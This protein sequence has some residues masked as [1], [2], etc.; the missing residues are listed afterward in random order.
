MH[1]RSVRHNIRLVGMACA[2]GLAALGIGQVAVDRLMAQGA[3]ADRPAQFEVDPFWPKQLPN[4]WIMGSVVGVSVDA[5]DRIWMIHRPSSLVDNEKAAA[6]NPP[7]AECCFPAPPV[8]VFD[9]AGNLV[10][11][12]G[13]AQPGSDQWPDSEHGIFVDHKG[14]V[15]IGGNGAK[16]AQ[17]MKFTQDGTFLMKIGN[18]GQGRGSND[19]QNFRQPTTVFVDPATNEAYVADGYGNRRVAVFDADTGAYKRHWGA[20]GNKPDDDDPYNAGSANVAANYQPDDPPAKQFGRAVHCAAVSKDGFVYV[21]DR[22]N[23]R[24]QVFRRDGTFVRETFINRKARG[25]GSAFE[26]G[27]ST[28][29]GQQFLFNVDGM[30]EKIDIIRRDTLEQVGRFGHKGRQPGQFFAVHSIA[31]DSRGNIY[32]GETLEGKRLQRFLYRRTSTRPRSRR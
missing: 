15:W 24:I 29:P 21:C 9:Q 23:N 5:N 31:V 27:F 3:R 28:D 22:T 17:V 30:D 26:V 13:G 18:K 7:R 14:N 20:Y 2:M 32:T 10:K 16:D 19:L 25:F 6:L 4:N 8:L 11:S 12:W 1:N